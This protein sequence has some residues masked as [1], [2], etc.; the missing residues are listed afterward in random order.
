MAIRVIS[1]HQEGC[2]GCIEQTA[3]NQEVEKDLDIE[4]DQIDAVKHP[5]YIKKFRLRVTPTIVILKDD[6]EQKRFEGLVHREE[7]EGE[8]KRLL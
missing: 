4:I 6:A 2:M 1:F 8:I 5:E 3:I 7:L